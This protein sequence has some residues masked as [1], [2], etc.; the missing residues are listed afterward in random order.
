MKRPALAPSLRSLFF[1]F[2]FFG[3]LIACGPPAPDHLPVEKEEPLRSTEELRADLKSDDW[4]TRSEAVLD[5]QKQGERAFEA[6]LLRLLESDASP[7]VRQIAALTL[8]DWQSRKAVP[9]I[10]KLLSRPEIAPGVT[11]D[12]TFML[13]AL[14]R[15]PDASGAAAAAA[16]LLDNDLNRRLYAVRALEAMQSG[17]A[18]VLSMA[19]RN[20]DPEKAR[21][22]VMA[23]GKLAYRPAESYLKGQLKSPAQTTQAA[24][25][26]ALGRVKSVSSV[27]EL[28][29][30]LDSDFVKGRENAKEAL[31]DIAMPDTASHVLALLRSSREE[32][33]YFAAEIAGRLPGRETGEKLLK[34]FQENDRLT[35]APAATALGYMKYEPARSAIEARLVDRNA[36]EREALARSLGWIGSRASI[37]PLIQVL[38][39]SDGDGRYGAAWSLGILEAE[40]ALPDLEKAANSGDSRLA[41]LAIEAIGSIASPSSL[42]LLV[43]RARDPGVQV[44]AIDAI[45]R[46]PGDQAVQEL[47]EL[48]TGGNEKTAALAVQALSGRKE[49]AAVDALIATLRKTSTESPLAGQ[50]YAGLHRQTG[51]RYTTKNQWLQWDEIRKRK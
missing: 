2:L 4:Q 17:G 14:Y 50:I 23:L 24:A 30:I 35:S 18:L 43:S 51:Q 46:I 29:K 15:M 3:G 33:R 47:E 1:S 42:P 11:V 49:P 20:T 45:G 10:V 40:E 6:D 36:A 48:A 27:P 34:M 16:Y 44:F 25:I 8:A 39:E 7:A 31:L 5:I 37:Q 12:A 38:R 28:V 41:S 13:D 9:I 26:L 21:A 22:L 19:Q 32:T